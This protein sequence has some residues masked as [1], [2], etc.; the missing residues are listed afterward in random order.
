MYLIYQD[1]NGEW[2]LRLRSGSLVKEHRFSK[3]YEAEEARQMLLL[4]PNKFDRRGQ[5]L[6]K[7]G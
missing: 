6:R 5:F 4:L 3:Y 7:A 1:I 2:V